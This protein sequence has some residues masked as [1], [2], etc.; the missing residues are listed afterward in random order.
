[1]EEKKEKGGG[2]DGGGEELKFRSNLRGFIRI[3]EC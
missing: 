2:A 3:L 1:M